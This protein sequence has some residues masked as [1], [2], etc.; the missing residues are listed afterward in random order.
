MLT[1]INNIDYILYIMIYVC[2]VNY[3]YIRYFYINNLNYILTGNM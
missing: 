2:K 3:G 1:I